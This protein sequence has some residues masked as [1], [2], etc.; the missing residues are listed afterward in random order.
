MVIKEMFFLGLLIFA[1]LLNIFAENFFDGTILNLV[2]GFVMRKTSNQ[3]GANTLMFPT[4]W[5]SNVTIWDTLWF[6]E[7]LDME[8]A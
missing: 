8:P 1:V 2:I 7:F 3:I 6:N 4:W 5:C